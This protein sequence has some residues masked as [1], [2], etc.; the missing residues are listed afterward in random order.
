MI[1][2]AEASYEKISNLILVLL[3]IAL[4]GLVGS[5][6]LYFLLEH[7][8]I[9]L[10]DKKFNTLLYLQA[11]A[12]GLIAKVGVSIFVFNCIYFYFGQF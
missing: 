10:T 8:H 5:I 12:S 6:V 3:L 1:D 2:L 7:N 11:F 9:S 4:G